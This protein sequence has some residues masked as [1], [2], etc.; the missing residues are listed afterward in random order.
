[1]NS[2]DLSG[3]LIPNDNK[4]NFE[5]VVVKDEITNLVAVKQILF[6]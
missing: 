2:N 4:H 5:V 3:V 1:M 6:S